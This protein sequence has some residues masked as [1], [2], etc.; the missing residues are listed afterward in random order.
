MLLQAFKLLNEIF[1]GMSFL[2]SFYNLLDVN[3]K[4]VQTF[5]CLC[6][7]IV[8]HSWS[9]AQVLQETFELVASFIVYGEFSFIVV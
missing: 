4:I 1:K 6:Y 9:F 7:Y 5:L 3:R 2:K 8:V